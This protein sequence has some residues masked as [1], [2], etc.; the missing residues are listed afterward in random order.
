MN[1]EY[2]ETPTD[3][4]GRRHN[5][6]RSPDEIE[7][8]LDQT[9]A[10]MEADLEALQDRLSPG[11]LMDEAM[12]YVR[13]GGAAEYFRN[14]GEAAKRNPVPL[15]LVG[16]GLAWLAFSGRRGSEHL[17]ST[18][19]AGRS[20]PGSRQTEFEYSDYPG[21]YVPGDTDLY[22]S[23]DDVDVLVVG[24]PSASRISERNDVL[25][26]TSGSA[27]QNLKSTAE[28]MKEKAGQAWDRASSSAKSSAADVKSK[29][30]ET[31]D[32]AR[33]AASGKAHGVAESARHGME[34]ARHGMQTAREQA[35]R[36]ADQARQQARRAKQNASEFI[37]EQPLVAA[38]IALTVGAIL[39]A[40][41]P[42]TR[43]ESELMGSRSEEFKRS[44]KREA[45]SLAEEGQRRVKSA[46]ESAAEAARRK[47]TG[48]ESEASGEERR[49]QPLGESSAS[50]GPRSVEPHENL[51]EGQEGSGRVSDQ[52]SKQSGASTSS[53][54]GSGASS[55]KGPDAGRFPH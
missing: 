26:E 22:G 6:D 18:G 13:T 35:R 45:E 2:P 41:L 15:A 20:Y 21:T 17:Q 4:T 54:S 1:R 38:G 12:R 42:S 49:Q 5:G 55:S 25:K 53:T 23:D 14:L 8:D 34:S 50:A 47:L 46:A 24:D 39:G 36:R 33:G 40:L 37:H 31:W 16:T 27:A 10:R 32:R 29:A 44:V 48:A 51:R 19:S 11:H 7:A 9:R 43:R 3:V 28:G 30:S 52:A